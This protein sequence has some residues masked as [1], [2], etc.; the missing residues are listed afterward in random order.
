M[1]AIIGKCMRRISKIDL[2]IFYIRTWGIINLPVGHYSLLFRVENTDYPRG[3]F[4]LDNIAITSC[5]YPPTQLS[6]YNSLLSFS[7]DFDNLTMCDMINGYAS[8]PPTF[9]F[10]VFTGD[11]VPNKKL[12]PFRDHT[13]N[14]TSGGF[15]YWDQHLPFTT[16][17]FGRVYPSKTIEQ[18]TGMCVKFAYYVKSEIVNKNGTIVG[19]SFGGGYGGP[20]WSQSLDDSQGWQIVIVPVSEFASAET[21]YFD[22]NQREP[23]DVSVAFDDIEID[24]CSSLIPTTTSTS[25]SIT[26]TT[27]MIT[28]SSTSTTIMSTTETTT[29]TTTTT[30]IASTSTPV[31]TTTS[32]ADRLLSLNG[33]SLIIIY[34]FSQILREYFLK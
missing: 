13:T 20:L 11:T 21:F 10:T 34:F 24:Q 33:C 22:V 26:T 14:S 7:C 32:H 5:D 1:P 16:T 18:N 3:S 29:T 17:D 28:T 23:I 4:A 15:L 19:V 31:T 6:P 27:E 8:S 9:N 2:I 12:G 25:T 30:S